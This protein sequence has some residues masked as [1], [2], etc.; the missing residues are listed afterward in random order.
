LLIE[1]IAENNWTTLDIAVTIQVIYNHDE[2]AFTRLHVIY[3]F[4]QV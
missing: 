4:I 1:Q 3:Y 2:V